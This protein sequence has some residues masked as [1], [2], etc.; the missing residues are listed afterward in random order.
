MFNVGLLDELR[1]LEKQ[2]LRSAVDAQS[3]SGG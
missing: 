1:G 2:L 3:A